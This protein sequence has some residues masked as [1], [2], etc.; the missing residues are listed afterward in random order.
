MRRSSGSRISR[1][2]QRTRCGFS[3]RSPCSPSSDSNLRLIAAGDGADR[4]GVRVV[5]TRW[6]KACNDSRISPITYLGEVVSGDLR[7]E[8]VDVNDPPV[9]SWVPRTR[10]VFDEVISDADHE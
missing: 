9:A 1:K 5:R 10:V 2:S 3:S 8:R 4:T 6:P 7:G